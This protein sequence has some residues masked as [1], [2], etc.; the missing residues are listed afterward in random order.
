[1]VEPDEATR[2]KV[3]DLARNPNGPWLNSC[4]EWTYNRFDVETGVGCIA[5]MHRKNNIAGT[6]PH[7]AVGSAKDGSPNGPWLDSCGQWVESREVALSTVG[8]VER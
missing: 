5:R 6:A 8:C 1:M 4:G 2:A 3:N 7:L